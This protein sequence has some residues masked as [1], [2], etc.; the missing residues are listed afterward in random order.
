MHKKKNKRGRIWDL[1][2][3]K[4]KAD[5]PDAQVDIIAHIHISTKLKHS[6]MLFK[7]IIN[8]KVN[9]ITGPAHSR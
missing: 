3:M 6:S 7:D 9:L 8:D 5:A 2:A 1:T 4:H